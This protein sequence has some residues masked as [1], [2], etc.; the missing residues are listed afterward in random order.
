[1]ERTLGGKASPQRGCLTTP[2]SAPL[3][4]AGPP[5]TALR[6]H[7]EPA[8]HNCAR[9]DGHDDLLDNLLRTACWVSRAP[10][11][12]APRRKTTDAHES[13]SH[14]EHAA[15]N[16]PRRATQQPKTPV[17][18]YGT[19]STTNPQPPLPRLACAR[20]RATQFRVGQS[21][22]PPLVEQSRLA[23]DALS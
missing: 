14:E 5:P 13:W 19:R 15:I 17:V 2:M 7:A 22:Q 9:Q 21:H 16:A 3:T 6:H 10:T 11:A 23:P 4:R 20:W 18:W 1:M 12:A 8:N